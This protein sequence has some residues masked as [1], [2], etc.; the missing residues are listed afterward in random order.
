MADLKI[1]MPIYKIDVENRLIYARATEETPDSAG[2]I[3]DYDSSVPY[4]KAWNQEFSDATGGKSLGNVR[5]MHNPDRATGLLKAVDYLDDEK[6]IDVCIKVVDDGD[7]A[8]AEEGVYTGVSQ[9]GSYIKIWNDPQQPAY[10]RYT[11]KPGELSLVDR[12]M[13]KSARFLAKLADGTVEE[14][15][16]AAVSNDSGQEGEEMKHQLSTAIGILKAH[17]EEGGWLL[18]AKYSSEDL[19]KMD[20]ATQMEAVAFEVL[21]KKDFTDDERKKLAD[22]GKALPDGSF[23]IESVE[24]LENAVKAYGRAKDKEEA[25]AHIIKRAKA[26]KATD[27]LPEDWEG[28]T[29]K[30]E[31]EKSDKGGGLKKIM[32]LGDMTKIDA[33]KGALAK[34]CGWGG[35]TIDWG[36]TQE[37][38]DVQKALSALS[39]LS[40]LIQGEAMEDHPEAAAQLS[41]LTT[42]LL[43]LKD[44]IS[45]EVQEVHGVPGNSA[46]TIT[47]NRIDGAGNL[48]KMEIV[49]EDG[50]AAEALQKAFGDILAKSGARHSSADL[51]K[52]QAIHDHAS[53]LG[54]TCSAEK[55]HKG[56][57]LNKGAAVEGRATAGSTTASGKTAGE[58]TLKKLD[59]AL[60]KLDKATETIGGLEK[61]LKD[62]EDA[63]DDGKALL[64]AHAI[65]REQD[66]GTAGP[67]AAQEAA[68][69]ELTKLDALDKRLMEKGGFTAELLKKM[70]VGDKT[71]ALIKLADRAVSSEQ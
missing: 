36:A 21:H 40:A 44:F 58:E 27:K 49:L 11:A 16:F 17:G 24:D 56:G 12:P 45:S 62:L 18:L 55:A 61:R 64:K 43:A 52:I 32:I 33:A 7:W 5:A 37:V 35:D 65:S 71:Q 39:Q 47:M 2:E 6:A 54:A 60:A 4:W 57:D 38:F 31:T 9:G 10:K 19:A 51:E 20:A 34:C 28:S 68:Q 69:A 42:A 15:T 59:G 8:K 41:S 25:K 23:P 3:F 46:P 53:T 48:Q 1:F 22:S 50:G 14:R 70:T 29:K 63:P 66:T 67:T 26:L 13:H 30:T